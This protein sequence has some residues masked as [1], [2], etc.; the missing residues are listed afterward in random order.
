M[1]V[2]KNTVNVY[3]VREAAKLPDRAH[4]GDAGMDFFFAPI[5]GVAVC[6]APGRTALLS[7]GV[8]VEV[9]PEY[10]LQVMNKSGVAY[11]RQLLVGACVVDHGYTGEIFVN[12][13]N[14]GKDIE[15]VNPGTKIAQ[16][17]FINVGRPTL[18][19]VTED[20]IYSKNTS[21]GDGAL[22]STGS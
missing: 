20:N 10:M 3:R 21:R 4:E 2:G 15:I 6:L 19:E 1:S 7:T 8:K 16:G 9:P 18:V 11:K 17:V 12:L 14:V 22:G 13:H 5:D